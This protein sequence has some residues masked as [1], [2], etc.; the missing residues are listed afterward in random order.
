MTYIVFFVIIVAITL[1]VVAT[2]SMIKENL[3][4]IDFYLI[5][6]FGVL[7][8]LMA[9]PQ[10]LVIDKN[11]DMTIGILVGID[12]NPFGTYTVYIRNNDSEQKHYCMEDRDII[13]YTKTLLGETVRVG[14]G[15]RVGIYPLEKCNQAPIIHIERWED[16]DN[17]N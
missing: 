12:E 16:Y 7:V 4:V 3:G 8:L 14:W 17:S 2:V 11:P 5:M 15:E 1:I 10:V 9:V 13:E 6:I